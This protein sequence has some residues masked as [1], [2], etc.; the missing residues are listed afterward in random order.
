MLD[1]KIEVIT[2]QTED[3][4]TG[5]V[6]D[7]IP[8]VYWLNL[9]KTLGIAQEHGSKIIKSLSE[10]KHY[11]KFTRSEIK[12]VLNGNAK[13]A[14]LPAVSVYY[15]LTAEGWNRAVMEISTGS[16]DNLEVIKKIEQIKDE[17][18]NIYTRYQKG[19]TL[20]LASDKAKAELPGDSKAAEIIDEN[21]AIANSFI[22]YACP[23]VKIDPG[24]VISTSLTRAEQLIQT[25]GGKTDLTH[26]K[27]MLPRVLPDQPATTTPSQ[28]GQYFSLQAMRVNDI[29]EKLGYQE[30]SYRVSETSG[31]RHKEWKPTP[32]G[33]PHGEWKPITKGHHNGSIHTGYKWYWKE[34]IIQE[35]RS[36]LFGECQ[37][38]QSTLA[39]VGGA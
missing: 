26:L 12:D 13:L 23:H 19:E 24:L 10:G 11:R 38:S 25:Y 4:L 21:L 17:M 15:F 16:M 22:K 28:I 1:S 2:A 39:A 33:E 35:F 32:K 36:G 3:N 27:G 20:S 14:L 30:S 8:H 7:G 37:S 29:L 9:Y 5:I 34:S 31:L 6:I 18:A